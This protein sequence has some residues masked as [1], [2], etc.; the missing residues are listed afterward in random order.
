MRA[1]V[2]VAEDHADTRLMIRLLLE[3]GGYEVLEAT[4]GEEAVSFIEGARP[5]LVLID[6][7]LPRLDGV[8]VTRRVRER[9]SARHTPIIF[10]SGRAEPVARRAAFDAGCDDYLVKPEGIFGLASVMAQHL[11]ACAKA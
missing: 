11:Q 4:N 10:L 6:G 5:D 1:R 8:A 3:R 2:L 7:E 9:E